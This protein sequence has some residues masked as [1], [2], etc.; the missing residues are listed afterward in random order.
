MKAWNRLSLLGVAA[1]L[2][3]LTGAILLFV[4]S[5][6]GTKGEDQPTGLEADPV[7]IS[8][9]SALVR[10]LLSGPTAT[11]RPPSPSPTASLVTAPSSA[12]P[13]PPANS[14]SPPLRVS[15]IESLAIPRFGVRGSIVTLGV[16]SNGA[17]ETPDGPTSIGWYGFSAHP[18][19]PADED[20]GNAVFSGHVDYY[21][22][23]PAVF[24]HVKDLTQG[25]VIEVRLFNGTLY[26]YSVISRRQY[27]A[28]NAPIL[29]IVGDTSTEVVTLI[30]CGG[31][32]DPSVGEYDDRIVVRAQRIY[33]EGTTSGEA[34]ASP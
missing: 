10:N 16:D 6:I 4:L 17:M 7:I 27:S 14:P 31:I 18:G 19:Y 24:W 5:L 15:S 33:E 2:C 21:N 9:P 28:S 3:I 30:T 26:Q 13:R 8:T 20:G 11:P 25:D 32:F 23:G 22:Y 29:D 34:H 12:P 1:G